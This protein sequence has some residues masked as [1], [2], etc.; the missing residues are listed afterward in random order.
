ME[1]GQP[2]P[3]SSEE[4]AEWEAFHYFEPFGAPAADDRWRV[5]YHLQ[6][7]ANFKGDAPDFLDRDPE[8]SARVRDTANAALSLEDKF[9][10]FFD[11]RSVDA[12]D[13]MPD[14]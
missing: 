14:A 6:W 7:C 8:E 1:T 4:L 12:G 5:A 10:L 13:V 11:T 9:A 2:A 3:L